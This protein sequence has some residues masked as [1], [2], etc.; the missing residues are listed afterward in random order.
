LKC[1]SCFLSAFGIIFSLPA[2]LLCHGAY[3]GCSNSRQSHSWSPVSYLGID[4]S[5]TWVEILFD[6][7]ISASRLAACREQEHVMYC[8]SSLWSEA[9]IRN[10]VGSKK[11]AS[12]RQN[13]QFASSIRGKWDEKVFGQSLELHECGAWRTGVSI[14]IFC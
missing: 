10:I 12:H 9:R 1:L 5:Y 4:S 6:S 7:F 11:E 2:F 13:N 14:S 3:L 8:L